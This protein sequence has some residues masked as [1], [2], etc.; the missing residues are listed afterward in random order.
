MIIKRCVKPLLRLCSNSSQSTLGAKGSF[1]RTASHSS[2]K[3]ETEK[4]TS[5]IPK[6]QQAWMMACNPDSLGF[7]ISRCGFLIPGT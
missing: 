1:A 5:L 4:E 2:P 3:L 6:V 7:W